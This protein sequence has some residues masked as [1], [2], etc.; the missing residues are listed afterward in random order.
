MSDPVSDPVPTPVGAS[1]SL[2]RGERGAASLLVLAVTGALMWLGV[3]LAVLCGLVLAQRQ[4][5]AAADLAALAGAGQR[6]CAA[7]EQVAR[8]NGADGVVCRLDGAEAFVEVRVVAPAWLL[9]T[10]DL[11]GQARAGPG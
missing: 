5:Q 3:G 2:V 4:A 6:D 1:R 7:A 8:A 11:H 9:G 10:R